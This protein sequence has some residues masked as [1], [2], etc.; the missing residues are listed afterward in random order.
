VDAVLYVEVYVRYDWN[1]S[2]IWALSPTL[3][4]LL[5][6]KLKKSYTNEMVTSH[7]LLYFIPISRPYLPSIT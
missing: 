3:P 4:E 7:F 1:A 2:G 6:Y 5:H